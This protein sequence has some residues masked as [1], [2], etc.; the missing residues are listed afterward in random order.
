MDLAARITCIHDLLAAT[1]VATL[2][3]HRPDGPYGSMV[4]FIHDPATG[5]IHIHLSALAPH[6][7]HLKADSRA[8]LL[9]TETDAP[10]KDPLAL[11]RV[12]VSGSAQP[13]ARD[14]PAYDEIK[15]RYL[16]RFPGAEVVFQL[17]DFRLYPVHADAVHLVAG[18]GKA[19][20]LG[21]ESLI[22][23]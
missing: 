2:S 6:S 18:F 15:N 21:P 7:R 11:V 19:Y 8:S 3:T 12:L 4:P 14:T 16:N 1:R 17:P 13:L 20:T 22:A 23:P 9:I 5:Q 10:D